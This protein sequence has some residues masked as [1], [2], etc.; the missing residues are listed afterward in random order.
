M[1]IALNMLLQASA[2][3]D[4]SQGDDEVDANHDETVLGP[5]MPKLIF[6]SPKS[7]NEIKRNHKQLKALDDKNLLDSLLYFQFKATQEEKLLT[8]VLGLF[9]K[10][11]LVTAETTTEGGDDSFHSE[12]LFNQLWQRV[13][14]GRYQPKVMNGSRIHVDTDIA[15]RFI[16][17]CGAELEKGD[18]LIDPRYILS[19]QKKRK[20]EIMAE[21][22]AALE[23]ACDQISILQSDRKL[24]EQMLR[25]FAKCAL[26]MLGASRFCFDAEQLADHM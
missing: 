6:A 4:V 16:D 18:S 17:C 20:E 10:R 24:C 11:E 12:P 3:F 21:A 5:L 1:Q 8:K 23:E 25:E 7:C 22:E 19:C 2:K 26:S 13:F 15:L 14:H 9:S